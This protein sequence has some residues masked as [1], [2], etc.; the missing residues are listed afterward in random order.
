VGWAREQLARE[1]KKEKSRLIACLLLRR[2][3][4][5]RSEQ[6]KAVIA[7]ASSFLVTLENQHRSR[8]IM[9]STDYTYITFTQLYFIQ[10]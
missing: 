5:G 10:A 4:L 3:A 6:W 1:N 9:H 2:D 8:S 7:I